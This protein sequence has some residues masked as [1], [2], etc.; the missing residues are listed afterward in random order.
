MPKQVHESYVPPEWH[1]Y[2]SSRFDFFATADE[3]KQF[4]LNELPQTYAPYSLVATKERID[5]R[6]FSSGIFEHST[7]RIIDMAVRERLQFFLR[8]QPLTP[9]LDEARAPFVCDRPT[10][11]EYQINYAGLILIQYGSFGVGNW[12]LCVVDEVCHEPTGKILKHDG[13]RK[14]FNAMKKLIRKKLIVWGMYDFGSV[15]Q[16]WKRPIMTARFADEL[17]EGAVQSKLC[18]VDK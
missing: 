16:E 12:D 7:A 18:I 8:S 5:E 2:R 10:D 9:D 4:F 13:Y 15:Q 6:N 1:R 14:L 11:W 17:R 3:I